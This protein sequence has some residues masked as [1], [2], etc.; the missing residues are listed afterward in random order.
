MK[1]KFTILLF[2]S[3]FIYSSSLCQINKK[4]KW[5]EYSKRQMLFPSS[6]YVIGFS[7]EKINKEESKEEMFERLKN[8]AKT[9]LIETIY[10][11]IKSITTSK[12][13]VENEETVS[14]IKQ[15]SVSLSNVKISGLSTETYYDKRR[16][17][18][19]VITYAKRNDISKLYKTTIANKKLKIEQ[20]ISNAKSFAKNKDL[21][22]ALKSYN[23]TGSIFR[24]IEEAQALIIA[25]EY[26]SINA[27]ELYIKEVNNLKLEVRNGITALQKNKLLTLS[28]VCYFISHNLKIQTGKINQT[29]R[30]ANF[31]YQDTKMASQFSKRMT[32]AFQQELV[33]QGFNITTNASPFDSDDILLILNGTYWEDG[34]YIK[35]VSV[36]RELKTGKAIASIEGLLP[37]KW[38]ES[39]NIK[40]KPNNYEEAYNNFVKFTKNQINST[41]LVVNFSTNKGDDNLIY[42]KGEVLKIYI[43]TNKECYIRFIYYLADGSKVLLLD[44]YFIG[45]SIVNKIFQI[46]HEF[47]CTDPY[48]VETLQLVAKTSRFDML[49]TYKEDGYEYITDELKIVLRKTRGFKKKTNQDGITEK[50]L[51]ITTM[52]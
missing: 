50:R 1:I 43:K 25:F 8:N 39:R 27:P 19:Y 28:D 10:V 35:I 18:C 42:T 34:D 51:I 4:P 15:S 9:Q 41:G 21:P 6:Q 47:E 37:K 7:S 36:L 16:S 24:D 30:L 40:F 20:E 48:G 23:N 3:F 49:N 5:I 32:V 26:K 2:I 31:T 38:L 22:N 13:A 44:N 46:P 11:K 52:E 12:I 33:N 45:N 14:S 17:T 29:I